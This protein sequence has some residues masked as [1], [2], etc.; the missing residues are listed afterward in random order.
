MKNPL[1]LFIA[2]L[3]LG[4]PVQS[5]CKDPKLMGWDLWPPYQ[6][7]SETGILI[8]I[9]I[10]LA[11][12]I[13]AKA[14]CEI[15][16]VEMPWKRHLNDLEFGRVD[17][18]PGA[19]FTEDRAKYAFFTLPYR[20]E[21]V[22]LFIRKELKTYDHMRSVAEFMASGATVAMV[23]GY[24][25]GPEFERLIES[26]TYAAYITQ[27]RSDAQLFQML[28]MKRI[29][30]FLADPYT[31]AAHANVYYEVNEFRPLFDVYSG[32]IHF[33]LSKKR[34]TEPEVNG[35]N[36]AIQQLTDDGSLAAYLKSQQ[37]SVEPKH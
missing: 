35:I 16:Y 30:G 23:L 25:Y 37:L 32:D 26:R 2:T 34:F 12:M 1:I 14:G 18:A 31:V 21:R 17:I 19:S 7:V 3:L 24:Y 33:M 27:V 36:Q 11:K 9:D 5:A 22:S 8:G 15:S 13:F 10:E 29:D 6:Y 20:Q 28:S 4:T